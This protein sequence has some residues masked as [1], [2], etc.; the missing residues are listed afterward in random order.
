MTPAERP[1]PMTFL[2]RESDH[3]AMEK[4]LRAADE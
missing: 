2:P 3:A 4:A 1:G